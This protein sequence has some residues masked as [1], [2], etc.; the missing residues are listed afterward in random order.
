MVECPSCGKKHI[1]RKAH[2]K[3]SQILGLK[4]STMYC[5]ECRPKMILETVYNELKGDGK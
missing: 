5:E 1:S 3:L 2:E 4:V